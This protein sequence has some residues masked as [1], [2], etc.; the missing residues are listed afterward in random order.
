MNVIDL[1]GTNNTP[2]NST[3]VAIGLF[4]GLHHGH[5]AVI[6]K[7]VQTAK[8]S[9][10]LSPAVF[11]F[12]TDTVISKGESGIDCILSGELKREL[13]AD[14]GIKYI[15]SPD[16][17]NF[18]NLSA[19]EFVELVL[20]DKLFAKYIC[21]GEDFRFGKG[22]SAD[23]N[24]L[25]KLCKK[26][27]IEVITIKDVTESSGKRIS[28]TMIRDMI[29]CGDIA[30]ANMLLGYH[31]QIKMPVAYGKQLGRTIE[32]PTINQYFPQ[33]QVVPRF[34]V[35][36]SLVEL[37]GKIYKG[38][39]N[40]GVK[41]TVQDSDLPLCET[42]IYGFDGNI[43]GEMVRLSLIE[44]IRP[45][46]KFDSLTELSQQINEDS[47]KVLNVPDEFFMT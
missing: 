2:E 22:A 35:Y 23:I 9:N 32:F 47:I 25:D 30:K 6:Q 20:Y 21:C 42:Y 26:K 7:A 15:Y 16:F 13:I 8:K 11:T 39:T 28:S 24:V 41:P 19:D 1:T 29:K 5:K 33:K 34:G 40:V 37:N 4:D 10:N 36:A 12:E 17:M 43:Y 14:M 45:E 38:L 31:Y 27:G 44:F 18:R 3:T 46:K